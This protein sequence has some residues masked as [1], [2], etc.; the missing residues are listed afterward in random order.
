VSR[1]GVSGPAGV[2]AATTPPARLDPASAGLGPGPAALGPSTPPTPE[3]CFFP[4]QGQSRFKVLQRPRPQAGRRRKGRSGP[5]R[6]R[7]HRDSWRIRR[8]AVSTTFPAPDASFRRPDPLGARLSRAAAAGFKLAGR[9]GRAFSK[10]GPS[11]LRRCFWSRLA[12]PRQ[13]R[14]T[15]WGR[16]ATAERRAEEGTD[17]RGPGLHRRWPGGRGGCT[18]PRPPGAWGVRTKRGDTVLSREAAGKWGGAGPRRMGPRL[19]GANGRAHPPTTG[20]NPFRRGLPL[21]ARLA[22]DASPAITGGGSSPTASF[23]FTPATFVHSDTSAAAPSGENRPRGFRTPK[24]RRCAGGPRLGPTETA[25]FAGCGSAR[26]KLG[27]SWD[28]PEA[29]RVTQAI[30]SSTRGTLRPGRPL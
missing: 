13:L 22:L 19:D 21:R 16:A 23:G 15:T 30:K 20:R 24:F 17:Q 11:P 8:V 4:S 6:P 18:R 3:G 28:V 2:S 1:C 10:L 27:S 14:P 5:A 29:P 26:K 9:P 25:T 12:R 7:R